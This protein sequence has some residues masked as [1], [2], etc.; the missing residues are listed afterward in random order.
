VIALKR[1]SSS[2]EDAD[3]LGELKFQ[4]ENDSDQQIN[5][6]KITAK[7]L[8]A[9]AGTEDGIIEFAIRKNGSNNIAA[10]F[11]SDSLQ[12]LNDTNLRVNGVVQLDAQSGDPS[13][14]SDLSTIYSKDVAGSAEVFVQDEAG[15]VTQISPHNE[16]GEWQYFS[17]NVK[18]GKVVKINMEKMI[19]KL[20]QITG[21]SF[22]EEW[23]E[24]PEES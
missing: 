17:K 4:G 19:R 20:E 14:A 18:T 1:N 6:A 23:F 21:E 5:Y 7:I 10:R 11:R 16:Y 3:Y 24:D 22:M 9:S 15:N 13:T 2:P 12:L 8:D